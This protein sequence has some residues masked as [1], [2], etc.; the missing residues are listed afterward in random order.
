[1]TSESTVGHVISKS[2]VGHVI[3]KSTV[4]VGHVILGVQWVM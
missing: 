1:M 4:L 3:S 2:T